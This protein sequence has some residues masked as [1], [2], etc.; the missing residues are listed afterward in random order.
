MSSNCQATLGNLHRFEYILSVVNEKPE[1]IFW[2]AR[3]YF[4]TCAAG[5]GAD[6]DLS[7]AKQPGH[8]EPGYRRS[9]EQRRNFLGNSRT[10]PGCFSRKAAAFIGF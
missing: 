5:F 9:T 1:K 7:P 10:I 2:A 3:H 6:E 8:E 4:S